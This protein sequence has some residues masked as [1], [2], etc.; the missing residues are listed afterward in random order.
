MPSDA[1]P[2][3]SEIH[4]LPAVNS[5]VRQ[6]NAQVIVSYELQFKNVYYKRESCFGFVG[7]FN[8]N[9]AKTRSC[10]SERREIPVTGR[11][12]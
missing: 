2:H 9:A 3:L 5:R 12:A 8:L 4:L 6:L 1:K 7:F 11:S 10:V